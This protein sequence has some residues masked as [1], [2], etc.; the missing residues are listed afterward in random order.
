MAQQ[1]HYTSAERGP[2]GHAG[3]QFV[4][5]STAVTP[6]V[7][8]VVLPFM[9]YRPPPDTPPQPDARQCAELPISLC[10]QRVS[11][12]MML[13][14]C[15]YL[16][17]DYSGRYGNFLGHAV[18][19]APVE[20][21]GIR[22]IELWGAAFWADR[23][24]AAGMLSEMAEVTPGPEISTDLVARH[25]EAL[26]EHGYAQLGALLDAVVD[27][28]AGRTGRVVLA[29]E[30]AG[31]VAVWI[32]ALCYSLPFEV[33]A[34]LSF[35]TYTADPESAQQR[36]VGTTPDVLAA[37]SRPGR[38]FRLDRPDGNTAAPGR[39]ARIVVDAWRSSNLAAIDELSELAGRLDGDGAD[40]L[41]AA[42]TLVA[43]AMGTELRPEESA[44]VVETLGRAG[45]RLPEWLWDNLAAVLPK[46]G[47]DLA[48]AVYGAADSR[49]RK[50]I[51]TA[52]VAPF[53]AALLA[54][55]DLAEVVRLLRLAEDAG[56]AVPDGDVV[57]AAAGCARR[58]RGDVLAAYQDCPRSYRTALLDG[59]LN[60]LDAT[61]DAVRRAMLTP[62][63][64]DWLADT[65][66]TLGREVGPAVW[67]SVGTRDPA[68]R[69]ESTG[70]IARQ[71][72][73]PPLERATLVAGM[74]GGDVPSPG[75]CLSMIQKLG[76]D[77]AAQ[78]PLL[79]LAGRPLAKGKLHVEDTAKLAGEIVTL[80]GVDAVAGAG[81]DTGRLAARAVADAH[82]VRNLVGLDETLRAGKDP[83]EPLLG[84]R[85]GRA[86][87]TPAL[88]DA[89]L[90]AAAEQLWQAHPAVRLDAFRKLP[91]DLRSAIGVVWANRG[92]RSPSE[93][94]DLAALV[95]TLRR[96]R[97]S[98]PELDKRLVRSVQRKS[99]R[100]EVHS[101]L[102]RR[103]PKLPAAL[104]DLLKTAGAE[105][106]G[107]LGRLIGKREN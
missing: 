61:D 105:K 80:S 96:E 23:P 82:L 51:A 66:W 79:A 13:V 25:L 3:F 89:V 49:R 39:F 64:C 52:A 35:T 50:E 11:G 81:G 103:D 15:R 24:A 100:R 73:R 12:R 92:Y 8:H 94:T 106:P 98:I 31:D 30:R 14:Q 88:A 33:A 53:V 55:E 21:E 59:V 1:L 18:V 42:G 68:R 16:G 20:L 44:S 34:E 54:A 72:D 26:G 102:R 43:F 67:V 90:Q 71:N 27:C 57:G 5:E 46:V 37:I 99:T 78:P 36:L 41:L 62:A 65:G 56:L 10:Y 17:Q 84:M 32:A 70:R 47:T 69:G 29:A 40:G 48:A 95:L 91:P 38:A 9:S 6:D 45:G 93:V 85:R 76:R 87:G 101:E 107:V 2:A 28:L 83:V 63:L 7:R 97:L 60:G 77:V 19:A 75:Q 74:W 86:T 22:P 104:D 58:G 4:A